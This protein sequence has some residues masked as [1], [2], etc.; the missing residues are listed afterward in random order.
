MMLTSSE[1]E[2]INQQREFL[3]IR[4]HFQKLSNIEK[5]SETEMDMLI[6]SIGKELALIHPYF[7]SSGFQGL[8]LLIDD[9][10][11]KLQADMQEY[12]RVKDK[13]YTIRDFA[14]P[15]MWS[16]AT[17]LLMR[18]AS[19][20]SAHIKNTN[21]E[22]F[23]YKTEYRLLYEPLYRFYV[24]RK[25][26]TLLYD[27]P[28]DRNIV[29]KISDLFASQRSAME[30]RNACYILSILTATGAVISYFSA[31]KPT[32]RPQ[33]IKNLQCFYNKLQAYLE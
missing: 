7:V 24:Q 13:K 26:I 5:M 4:S 15:I 8:L 1:V 16:A 19:H 10:L 14:W 29:N 12:E 27:Y 11:E 9:E 33:R 20:Y 3:K 25:D 23:P 21:D 2:L 30:N 6:L 31:L 28:L 32:P 18:T 22:L 17:I